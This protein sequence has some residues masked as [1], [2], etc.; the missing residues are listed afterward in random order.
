M[1][2]LGVRVSAEEL[3]WVQH[4]ASLRALSLSEYVREAINAR[5]RREGVD[6]VLLR[7]RTEER[8]AERRPTRRRHE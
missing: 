4:A 5:L 2:R 8:T 6:A 3:D 7:E 1:A